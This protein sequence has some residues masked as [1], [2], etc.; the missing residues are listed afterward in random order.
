MN[1]TKSNLI[2]ILKEFRAWDSAWSNYPNKNRIKPPEV[3]VFLDMLANDWI[4]TPSKHNKY[5]NDIEDTV[6]NQLGLFEEDSE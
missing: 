4:V 6:T 3:D 2:E 5:F 1:S